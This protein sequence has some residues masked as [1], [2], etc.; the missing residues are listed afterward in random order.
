MGAWTPVTDQTAGWT[1]VT[2][3]N[4]GWTKVADAPA[5]KAGDKGLPKLN[6]NMS[7]D[8]IIK[9]FGYDPAKIKTSPLF[10]Q[11][12]A[13]R[14]GGGQGGF[15]GQHVQQF[16][17][18]AADVPIGALQMLGH[19]ANKAGV[20]SDQSKDY[21]DLLTKINEANYQHNVR[22]D[23]TGIDFTRGAGN[24]AAA[25][26]TGQPETIG[27]RVAV[28]AALSTLNPETSDTDHY[29]SGKAKQAAA[30]AVLGAAG[31]VA[32]RGVGKGLAAIRGVS[33]ASKDALPAGLQ[34][35]E[36]L[37]AKHKV[38]LT[39]GDLTG[40]PA[41]QKTEVQAENVPFSGMGKFRQDQQNATKDA[42]FSF[43]D[44]ANNK[45]SKTPYDG[46]ALK[47]V[48]DSADKGNKGAV[49]L[50]NEIKNEG[51]DTS[52]ILK[53]SG[54]LSL[55]SRKL[56]ANKL[57]D[58]VGKLAGTDAVPLTQTHA[59]IDQ[60]LQQLHAD[61]IPDKGLIGALTDLKARTSGIAPPEGAMVVDTPQG[62]IFSADGGKSFDAVAP[63]QADT[64]FNGMRQA[65]SKLGDKISDA[66]KG[67]DALVGTSGAR[68]LQNV[69]TAMG[70]D[71]DQFASAGS[72]DLKQASD[73][74]NAYYRDNVVPFK[75]S[76][77]A[78]AF[79]SEKTLPD[80]IYN[81]FLKKGGE[82][83]AKLF[84]SNLDDR[85][86][87]A[88]RSGVL[89]DALGAGTNDATGIFSPV[90]FS[91]AVRKAES[92]NNVFFKGQDRSELDGFTKLMDHVT[93]AGQYA[94]NPPT[95]NRLQNFLVPTLFLHNPIAGAGV[96][97]TVAGF[98]KLTTSPEG[99]RL[100]L[101]ASNVKPGSAQMSAIAERAAKLIPA[102]TGAVVA[103]DSK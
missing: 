43:I 71:L 48:Q 75:T 23:D 73:K 16:A 1:K 15:L 6:G 21:V 11:G 101:S 50:L 98:R 102:A 85:G 37:A 66:Y 67:T 95:G 27:G 62:K 28:G 42:A 65:M 58:K 33:S 40:S 30:G 20:L 3:P 38:P 76:R 54:D 49:A 22:H 34:E 61:A 17:Q 56:T 91:S 94:E 59:A 82:D 84:Y 79:N 31:E 103:E 63:P 19:L 92:V 32:A 68:S 70:A 100:L 14:V 7:D 69:R 99:R 51:D 25:L 5:P 46:G 78:N 89:Q 97:G 10:R 12:L 9:A 60:E 93:R 86:R 36:N 53:N 44:Q 57:Y 4:A 55:M 64:S 77:L 29:F 74:A 41:L 96:S 47:L 18:G 24:V 26:S 35:V 87:A 13:G 81:G 8:D 72:A 83:N 90:K 80:E 88:V 39:A 2:D 45:L 52:L